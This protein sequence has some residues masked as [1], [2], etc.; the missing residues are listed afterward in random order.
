MG[1]PGV[2]SIL[3]VF[4]R[5]GNVTFGGGSATIAELERELIERRQWVSHDQSRLSYALSRITPGT[6]LLAY[7]TA[8]GWFLRGVSGA[9]TTL[10][11]ASVPCSVL[12]VFVTAL[13]EWWTL[14]RRLPWAA[15]NLRAGNGEAVAM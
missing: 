11:A 15:G 2:R 7:C 10:L 9:I 5:H 1:T 4:T 14:I 12:A 6:N 13:Y 3:W 8:V